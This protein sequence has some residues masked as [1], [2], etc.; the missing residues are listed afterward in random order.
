[1]DSYG[2]THSRGQQ[3]LLF[4]VDAEVRGHRGQDVD[5]LGLGGVVHDLELADV[6]LHLL[7][8]FK[9]QHFWLHSDEV[10]CTH[11]IVLI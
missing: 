11:H 9:K 7:E 3:P 8:A 10:V 2:L 5:P 1:M 6:E 4:V